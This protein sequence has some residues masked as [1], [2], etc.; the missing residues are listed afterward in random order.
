MPVLRSRQSDDAPLQLL[1]LEAKPVRAR[2]VSEQH[3]PRLCGPHL[4]QPQLQPLGQPSGR[5]LGQLPLLVGL[6]DQAL[7]H[8][9]R[10]PVALLSALPRL[11]LPRHL[12]ESWRSAVALWDPRTS[13]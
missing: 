11:S 6:D 4:G 10:L 3:P 12:S 5:L 9:R 8:G 7:L 2:V 1:L 13:C